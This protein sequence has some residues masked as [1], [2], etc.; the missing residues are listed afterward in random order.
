M[1]L[2][3][4]LFIYRSLVLRKTICAGLDDND[5]FQSHDKQVGE[6]FI[7]ET[8]RSI[9]KTAVCLLLKKKN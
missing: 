6:R 3:T 9:T 4:V 5:S 8:R 2:Q 1:L 7:L